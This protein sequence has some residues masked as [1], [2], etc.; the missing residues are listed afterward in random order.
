MGQ[1]LTIR[2][3]RDVAEIGS[4]I[5][6]RRDIGITAAENLL[7]SSAADESHSYSKS[8]KLTTQEDHVKQIG[9]TV[10]AGGDVSLKAGKDMSVVST[11]VTAGDEAYLVAGGNLQLL[12]AQ[13]SDYSLYDKKKKGSWGSKQT[14]RDEVTKITHVGSEITTGGDLMLI[15]GTDQRY[16]VAKLNSGG[17]LTLQSGGSITFEGVKDLHQESHEK[18]NNNAFWVSSKGKGHT[19]ETFRQTQ[20]KAAGDVVIKAV[21]GLRIDAKQINQQTVSQSIDAMVKADPQLAWLKQAEARGDVDW[22]QVREIHESFKYSN[23]G[24]GPASQIIIAILMAAVVG[25][26]VAGMAGGGV[27]GS[28]AGAVA[29]NV[30]T[31]ATVS[32]INNGGDLG[33]VIKDVTSSDAV[34][35]YAISAITAGLTAAYFS[36]WTGTKTNTVTG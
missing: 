29:S 32:A 7:L 16:Q 9:S 1:D 34:K 17:D 31:N 33:A 11:R 8:K 30:S 20:M 19:N 26:A 18:T 4:Q 3:G 23:S 2:A 6:A 12:A 35:N 5:G 13:D 10:T 22:R 36:D 24:L 21:G 15:S 27:G 28:I 14:K 25:P